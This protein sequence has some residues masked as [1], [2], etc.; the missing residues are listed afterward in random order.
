MV[1]ALMSDDEV[2]QA[3]AHRSKGRLPAI[4]YRH[5]FTG[6]VMTRSAQPLV[7]ITMKACDADMALLNYYR[8]KG[9]APGPSD[10]EVPT[11]FYIFDARRQIAATLNMAAGKGTE[12]ASIYRNTDIIFCD[13]D[14]IHVM[15]SAATAFADCLLPGAFIPTTSKNN[16]NAIHLANGS[17]VITGTTSNSGSNQ[18]TMAS[19]QVSSV[20]DMVGS[21]TGYYS[22]LEDSGWLR[23]LRLILNASVMVAEKMHLEGSSVLIHCSDGW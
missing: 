1:P 18:K 15:R 17:T 21:G 22:K 9:S 7:G 14:N 23:Y 10:F 13:I 4:T 12:D 11:K 2:K 16:Y 5:S 19:G 8:L 6:A 20:I 3:I